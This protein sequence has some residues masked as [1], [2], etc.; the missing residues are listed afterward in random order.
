MLRAA[1]LELQAAHDSSNRIEIITLGVTHMRS[2]IGDVVSASL[3]RAAADA[4]REQ[5]G[6]S[7]GA[8]QLA[9][10]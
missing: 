1:I 5:Y 4:S 10:R 9:S 8:R 3:V 7:S 2:S 6:V